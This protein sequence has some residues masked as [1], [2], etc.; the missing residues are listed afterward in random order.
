MKIKS[1]HLNNISLKRKDEPLFNDISFT[2]NSGDFI[3]IAG[4]SGSGKTTLLKL[5][6]KMEQSESGSILIN[7]ISIDHFN[8]HTLRKKI[9]MIPQDPIIIDGSIKDNLLMPFKLSIYSKDNIP[10]ED[11]L[12][13]FLVAFN[14][15]KIKLTDYAPNLSGGQK[16]RLSIIRGIIANPDFLL[17][18]EPFSALDPKNQVTV[19]QAL[20]KFSS[21]KQKSIIMVSHQGDSN[22]FDLKIK[23]YIIENN[24][25]WMQ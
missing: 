3:V 4:E 16:L 2:A 8:I 18:D 6:I 7:N 21:D 19:I 15:S 1:I 24:K 17:L 23:K 20:K 11:K 22:L 13:S 5:I 10:S 25:I 9:A 12:L 14:L